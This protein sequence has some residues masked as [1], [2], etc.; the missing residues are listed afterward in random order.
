MISVI[1]Q[2]IAEFRQQARLKAGSL[3]ISVFGDAVAPRGGRIW[4]G[5]LITLLAPLGLN[6][7]LVRTSVFRLSRE[8]WLVAKPLGRRSDYMLSPS[9]EKRVAEAT[10]HIYS[11][12]TPFWDRRWRLIMTV[13]YLTTKDRE[14]LRKSLIW[15]G[16]GMLSNHCFIHPSADLM[17]AFDALV[18]EGLANLIGKL[19]PLVAAD[20]ASFANAA[21]DKD[22]VR[23]A[24]DLDHLALVYREFV[25]RYDPILQAYRQDPEST[26][27]EDAFLLRVLLIHD[28]R[29]LLLRDPT[30]PDVLLPSGWPGQ[31]ARLLCNELYQRLLPAS[32]RHLDRHFQLADGRTPS[33]SE[34]LPERF[35]QVDPLAVMA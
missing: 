5:S 13:G 25:Q 15:Q 1:Q 9:G 28:Y 27:D 4:L 24:W 11:S 35:V 7:R 32:E 31:K 12:T 19:K 26:S 17:E 30:L 34:W 29:R 10:R 3:I 22:M 16:F 21:S 18:A 2:R 23:S 20:P 14:R 6:E 33:S 8:E